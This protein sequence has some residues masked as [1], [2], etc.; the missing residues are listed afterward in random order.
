LLLCKT[1]EKGLQWINEA[2]FFLKA[3]LKWLNLLKVK[4]PVVWI[5]DLFLENIVEKLDEKIRGMK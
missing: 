3:G 4:L 5:S 2:A 1:G